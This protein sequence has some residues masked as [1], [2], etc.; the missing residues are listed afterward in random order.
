MAH[1]ITPLLAYQHYYSSYGGGGGFGRSIMHT[2]TNAL[3]YSTV[4]HMLSPLFRG[5]GILGALFLGIAIIAVVAFMRRV[6]NW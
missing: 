4:S 1:L 3:L 5:H 6:F 2:L